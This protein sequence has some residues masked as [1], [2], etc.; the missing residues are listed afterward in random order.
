MQYLRTIFFRRSTKILD[1][2]ILLATCFIMIIAVIGTLDVI[3]TNL[4]G[5]AIAGAYELASA[6]MAAAAFLGF[7][8]AQ[9]QSRHI[10]I[11]LLADKLPTPLKKFSLIFSNIFIFVFMGFLT[12]QTGIMAFESLQI[13]ERSAGALNFPVYIFKIIAFCGALAATIESFKGI[14]HELRG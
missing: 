6:S 4:W 13:S 8:Y 11:D 5:K 10:K 7:H 2:T 3:A 9:K 1:L 14:H 12:W